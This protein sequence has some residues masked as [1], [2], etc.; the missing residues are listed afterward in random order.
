VANYDP[1]AP[2]S[3]VIAAYQAK[4]GSAPSSGALSIF[5]QE[6]A[7]YWGGNP[8]AS[9]SV[10]GSGIPGSSTAKSPASFWTDPLHYDFGPAIDNALSGIPILGPLNKLLGSTADP[11]SPLSAATSTTSS[12][13]AFIT[14]IPRVVTTL[15][16][17]VLIIAGIFALSRGPAVNIVSSAVR[18]AATS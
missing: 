18:E 10:A 16:G 14:D 7:S 8:A 12:A 17:L 3:D 4:Y 15:L 5:N 1:Y 9:G 2:S 6:N 11:N 13:L